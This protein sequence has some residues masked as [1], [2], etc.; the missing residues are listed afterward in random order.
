[1][2]GYIVDPL[3]LPN[4]TL[5]IFAEWPKMVSYHHDEIPQP[6]CRLLLPVSQ[7]LA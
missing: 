2:Q 1:M 4:Q 3:I 6:L 5:T 7:F